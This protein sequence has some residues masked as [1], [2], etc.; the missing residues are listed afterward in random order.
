MGI[1]TVEASL[2]TTQGGS[3]SAGLF[4]AHLWVAESPHPPNVLPHYKT[5]ALLWFCT[6]STWEHSYLS[7][8]HQ[9]FWVNGITSSSGRLIWCHTVCTGDESSMR[10]LIS[11]MQV[12]IL[13]PASTLPSN[14]LDT[15]AFWHSEQPLPR[16]CWM[17]GGM[18]FWIVMNKHHRAEKG[19]LSGTRVLECQLQL[20]KWWS[21]R[22]G[23]G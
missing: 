12:N 21:S 16:C 23:S 20:G 11:L 15:R 18:Q 7:L 13:E 10:L 6:T 17:L 4:R 3:A 5:N 9:A 14:L 19:I 1:L 2:N 8:H 22:A